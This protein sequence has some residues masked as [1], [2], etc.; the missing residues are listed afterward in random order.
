MAE[1]SYIQ[2]TKETTYYSSLYAGAKGQPLNDFTPFMFKGEIFKDINTV[3]EVL[4][5]LVI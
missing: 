2:T 4:D 1:L 5:K 3:E